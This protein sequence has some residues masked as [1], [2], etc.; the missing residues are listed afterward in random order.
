V[1]QFVM[2]EE[3]ATVTICHGESKRVGVTWDMRLRVLEDGGGGG[4]GR[5]EGGVGQRVHKEIAPYLQRWVMV[6]VAAV[7]VV[8]VVVMVIM[9]MTS[10]TTTKN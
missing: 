3:N 4:G 7:V 5:L 6:V 9:M 1:L 8:V 10:V 2:G